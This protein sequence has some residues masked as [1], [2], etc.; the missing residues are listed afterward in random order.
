RHSGE[1]PAR[2]RGDARKCR[3]APPG[4]RGDRHLEQRR[5]R[6][7]APRG[8]GAA[9]LRGA[10]RRRHRAR[11]LPA[12]ARGRGGALLRRRGRRRRPRARAARQRAGPD[13]RA[14][15]ALGRAP[16]SQGLHPRG[17]REAP[18]GGRARQE[19][20]ERE[21]ERSRIGL[22]LD[23]EAARALPLLRRRIVGHLER[24]LLLLQAERILDAEALLRARL[25]VAR[26]HGQDAVLVDPEG[27]LDLGLHAPRGR[28]ALE[29]ERA[30]KLVLQHRLRAAL[31]HADLHLGLAVLVGG[32][33]ALVFGRYHHVLVDQHGEELA[34]ARDAERQRSDVLQVHAARTLVLG[35]ALQLLHHLLGGA[36]GGRD[37]LLQAVLRGLDQ[38]GGGAGGKLVRE[39]LDQLGG[40]VVDLQELVL[41]ALHAGGQ[42][43]VAA[44]L[45]ALDQ[46][47]ELAV[48]RLLLLGLL[49]LGLRRGLRRCGRPGLGGGL[50][51]RLGGRLRGGLGRRPRA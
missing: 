31:E 20:S 30:E 21:A 34:G 51:R 24:R 7:A 29:D 37:A 35:G 10:A 36:F 3:A 50:R 9:R 12:R 17:L 48:H 16:G 42:V 33:H 45:A 2:H 44:D 43:L 47:G 1:L 39:L 14:G 5:D 15:G 25:G 26:A 8:R 32:E 19:E 28:D 27:D 41:Q 13:A 22:A 23:L 49:G 4:R 40:L 38:L 46:L 18:P 6:G 11:G